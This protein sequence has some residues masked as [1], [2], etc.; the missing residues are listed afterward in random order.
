MGGVH[1][2]RSQTPRRP[3]LVVLLTDQLRA[4]SL[5]LFGEDQIRTP[6]IDRLAR[7]GTLLTRTISTCPVCTPAR[8]MLLT[9]RHPQTTGHLMNTVRTRH[10]EISIADALARRGYRT[11]W[12]GKWHLHT[13]VWPAIDRM[14]QHP[15]W[16]P[17]GRDRLGFE[18]WRAYN[19]H[20]VYFD[21]FVHG[22]D[23]NY[24][25]WEGYETD[26]LLK[27]GIEFMDR[28]GDQ[29]FCLFLS[30]HQPHFT[31][32]EFAP[33]EYYRRLPSEIR[34]PGNVP[35]E[36]RGEATEMYRHYLAMIL[37][38]DDMVGGLLDY[39]DRTGQAD[40]TLVVFTSDHGSEGGAH[41][42]KPW[43]KKHPHEES[44]HVPTILRLPGVFEPGSRSDALTA[45]VDV[46]PS[47]CGLLGVPAPRS[48]E[49][50]DLSDAWLGRPGAPEQDAVLLMNFSSAYDW[51]EDGMEWRGVRTAS[52]IYARWLNGRVELYDIDADPLQMSNL[53][54]R[55]EH[56]ETESRL[57]RRMLELME[58]RGDRL[59]PC[60]KMKCWY[61]TQ[62]R[63]VR[64]AF[65]D[66]S[67]PESTPDWS[68]L[69]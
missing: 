52:H 28:S 57:E 23:W 60:S 16:V 30:P 46:F 9:G 19:Q 22:D 27:F 43:L 42:S 54:G 10:S 17:E 69:Y 34:L 67:G 55:P 4:A 63:V 40:D 50:L 38:I 36:M 6:H 39:L 8:A 47:V 62:R 53:A 58:A 24:M 21:G 15:D 2:F 5:P 13:G 44:L 37:A 25:R 66:L 32:F 11:G 45:L 12:V 26:G 20:M 61:D 35:A 51:L 56:G 14:P 29:P 3:N 49:G 59:V 65:G 68:L 31:P 18:F 33:E 7:E 48:V 64:N 41:G 1:E